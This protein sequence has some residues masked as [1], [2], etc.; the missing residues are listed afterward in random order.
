M[1][2]ESVPRLD[3]IIPVYNEG[4]NILQALDALLRAVRT[5]HRVLICYDR[6]DDDTL[7]AIEGNRQTLTGMNIEFVRNR[8]SGAHSAVLTGFATSKAPFIL[9]SDCRR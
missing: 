9:V 5:P 1:T 2:S 6:D 8:G 7:A 3:I 4:A